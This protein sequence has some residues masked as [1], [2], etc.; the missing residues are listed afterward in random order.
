M[1]SVL[2]IHI[3]QLIAQKAP[4]LRHFIPRFLIK[5]LEK[6][7]HQKEINQSLRDFGHLSGLPFVDAI[8]QHHLHVSYEAI[9]L[10][11]IP[12]SGRYIF[13]SNHPLGAL[14]GL[15][16]MDAIGK[17]FSD[18]RFVVNDILMNLKPLQPLFVPVNKYGRQ[19]VEN[20]EKIRHLYQS[21]TQILYFP[22][23]LCSRKIKGEI[24]DLPWKNSFL[25]NAIDSHRDIV[26]I[27]FNAQNSNKFYSIANFRKRIGVKFNVELLWLSDEL[28]KK[29]NT[30]LSFIVG[31][32]ISISSLSRQT[33]K[34][35]VEK[36]RQAVYNLKP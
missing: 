1:N 35:D 6:L 19:S 25:K 11:K 13:V 4:K 24:I 36:I 16:L 29:R 33:L 15:I 2:Q 9:G 8:L 30:H 12:T 7:I 31:N 28:Y 5:K 3:N 20:I 17:Y 10:D 22:A 23:G 21:D 18:I 27:Y 32:P 26:P 14:D 34:E